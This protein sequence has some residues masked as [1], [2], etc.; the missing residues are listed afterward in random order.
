MNTQRDIKQWQIFRRTSIDEPFELQKVYDFDDSTVQEKDPGEESVDPRLVEKLTSPK[1]FYVDFDFN[2]EAKFIYSVCS[3]DAHGLS[4]NYGMQFEVS[5]DRYKNKIQKKLISKSG[6][7]KA[8][9]NMLLERDTFVD[10][11]KDT[12]HKKLRIVF[13]PEYLK[14][15]DIENN[16]L[17]L[18]K[19]DENSVYRLSLINADLQKQTIIDVKLLNKIRTIEQNKVAKLTQNKGQRFGRLRKFQPRKG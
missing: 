4:S 9:P 2:K 18:L 17:G 14:V 19:T 3:V 7:P 8:Y 15:K 12:G 10:T 16:D 5:F 1:N 11:I 6:A 13:S